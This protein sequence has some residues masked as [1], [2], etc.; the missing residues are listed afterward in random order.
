MSNKQGMLPEGENHIILPEGGLSDFVETTN[1]KTMPKL[2]P[3]FVRN[4]E[5]S[6]KISKN[7]EIPNA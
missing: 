1:S 6:V 7:L 2:G 3:K 4:L 5:K